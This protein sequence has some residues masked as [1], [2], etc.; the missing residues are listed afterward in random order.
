MRHLLLTIFLS[1]YFVGTAQMDNYQRDIIELLYINGTEREY[2]WMFDEVI[3]S[4]QVQYGAAQ[5]PEAFWQQLKRDRKARVDELLPDLSFGYRKHYTHQEIKQLKELYKMEAMQNAVLYQKE[6][7]E[8]DDAQLK[9]FAASDLGK[10]M[11]AVKPALQKDL[12]Q[13]AR[14]WKTDVFKAKF[15]ALIR[16]GYQAGRN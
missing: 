8:V 9:E 1:V 3:H 15:Q 10:K 14:Y 16:A 12:D 4:L 11:V 2:G 6:L 13:I 7:W 5:V